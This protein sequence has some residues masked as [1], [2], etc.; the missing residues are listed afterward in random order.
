LWPRINF[1]AC[2]NDMAYDPQE[3]E[4]EDHDPVELAIN[5]V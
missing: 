5:P 4:L 1:G 2:E 3:K